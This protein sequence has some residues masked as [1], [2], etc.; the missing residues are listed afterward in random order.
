MEESKYYPPLDLCKDVY[1]ETCREAVAASK[2]GETPEEKRGGV[3]IPLYR[4]ILADTETPVSAFM[5]IDEGGSAYLLESVEGGE[6]WGRYSILGNSSV[7]TLRSKGNV[8]EVTEGV[9]TTRTTTRSEGDPVEALREFTGRYRALHMEGLP[10]FFGGAI[11]FMGYDTV[12]HIEELPVETTDDLDLYDLYFILT[13][14]LLV[15]DNIENKI[16]VIANIYIEDSAG[17]REIEK[18]YREGRE[19][20]DALIERLRTTPIDPGVEANTAE[21]PVISNFNKEDFL[22]AVERTKE[23]IVEGD[24]FQTVLSQ[25][26]TMDL[27]VEDFNIYRALRVINPS[28]YLFYLRLGDTTVIGSSPEILVTVDEGEVTVRPI[29]GTRKRGKTE[30]EDLAL[31]EDLLSDP[32]ELAEHIM[33]V[34]LGRNDVGRVARAGTVAVSDFQSI[35]RY[36]H[37]MHIVSNVRATLKDGADHFDALR[38]TFPAGTLSGAPKV[39]AM[40]II[41]ELEP[42]RRSIYGG[43]VGYIGFS[44][45]MDMCIAIRTMVIKDGKIYIQA[46]AGIVADSVPESEFEE[47]ENKARAVFKAVEMAKAGLI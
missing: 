2:G 4:D 21:T 18:L 19:K 34:D 36:S 45:N 5:K 28:P 39:R 24:I 26:F 6:K 10:K 32:K 37:V 1:K 14:T 9:G 25:R 31:E 40:E 30:E 20:I 35:E 42:T 43:A 46:G 15:F 23:Y 7:A 38:A 8:T 17:D 13:D 44:S 29:A 41:E 11:G 22:S 27:T 33:L 12:R 47:T 16:K 3:V